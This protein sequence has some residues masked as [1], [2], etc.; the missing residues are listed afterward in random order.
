MYIEVK[1]LFKGGKKHRN[2]VAISYNLCGSL[3]LLKTMEKYFDIG[4]KAAIIKIKVAE[5]FD[6]SNSLIMITSDNSAIKEQ[7]E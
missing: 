2:K 6:K 3:Q 4:Q 1:I 5:Q 7:I